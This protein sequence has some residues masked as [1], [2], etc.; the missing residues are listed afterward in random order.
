SPAVVAVRELAV[1][2]G[3][4]R[5]VIETN[6]TINLLAALRMS[7]TNAEA[8]VPPASD[9]GASPSVDKSTDTKK[10]L[11]TGDSV[12]AT[13]AL[14][15]FPL[16]KLSVGRVVITNA[17]ADFTDRSLKP[18]VNLSIDEVN[19][20]VAGLSSDKLQHADVDLHAKVDNAGPVAI[21]GTINPFRGDETNEIKIEVKDVDLTAASSYSG[22]FAGYRIAKGKLNL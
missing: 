8:G 15:E 19:G 22:R 4:A 14:A 5:V 7:S 12:I 6:R 18:N 9:D 16:K 1:K 10:S 2:D 11:L 20:T 13:N 17:H 21:S 3:Y